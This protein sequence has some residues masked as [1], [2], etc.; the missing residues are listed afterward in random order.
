MIEPSVPPANGQIENPI[1]TP[2]GDVTSE[3]VKEPFLLKETILDIPQE[4]VFQQDHE[5]PAFMF[6]PRTSGYDKLSSVKG[7]YVKQKFSFWKSLFGCIPESKYY[8][9]GLPDDGLA[10]RGSKMFNPF[11][12]KNTTEN[13][14]FFFM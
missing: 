2:N 6:E 11:S 10:K 13:E 7:A 9:Y 8:V 5:Q 12:L 1:Q 3:E 14:P 4:L